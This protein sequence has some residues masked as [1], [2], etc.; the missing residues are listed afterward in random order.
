MKV[1]RHPAPVPA[2]LNIQADPVSIWE[3]LADEANC[4]K[5]S[6][7]TSLLFSTRGLV[8]YCVPGALKQNNIYDPTYHSRLVSSFS[9]QAIPLHN[10]LT[11][12]IL[13]LGSIC[14]LGEMVYNPHNHDY[15]SQ[16]FEPWEQ[17]PLYTPLP[18]TSAVNL[19]RITFPLTIYWTNALPLR[20]NPSTVN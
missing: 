4:Q 3:C 17:T 7:S 20:L 11:W 13:S 9:V 5:S 19:Y 18:E 14:Y 2:H 1:S 10:E 15:I 8:P 6:G 16:F 12:T